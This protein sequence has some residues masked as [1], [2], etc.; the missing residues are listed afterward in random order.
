M[1]TFNNEEF[2]DAQTGSEISESRFDEKEPNGFQYEQCVINRALDNYTNHVWNDISC[3][4]EECSLCNINLSPTYT[5]R[6]L[7]DHLIDKLDFYFDISNDEFLIN[8]RHR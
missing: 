3:Y 2:V 1:K 7:P 5:L 6:G 8:G 4:K